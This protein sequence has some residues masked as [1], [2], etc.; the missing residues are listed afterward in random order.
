MNPNGLV[1]PRIAGSGMSGVP[2]NASNRPAGW[3]IAEQWYES[4]HT[5]QS[6]Y[7]GTARVPSP[8]AKCL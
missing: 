3:Q 2:G 5:R 4:S 6:S 1:T 8:T 7:R